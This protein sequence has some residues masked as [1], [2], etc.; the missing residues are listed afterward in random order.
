M[1][2]HVWV[3]AIRP[4]DL[5]DDIFS[6]IARDGA[7]MVEIDLRLQKAFLALAT[8]D[9]AAFKGAARRHSAVSLQRADLELK[10]ED[11]RRAVRALAS[12]LGEN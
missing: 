5:F 12:R 10:L 1:Y 8:A 9:S 11:E 3:P 7:A 2:P 4:D 6:P